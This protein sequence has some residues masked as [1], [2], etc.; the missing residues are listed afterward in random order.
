MSF[1]EIVA[2][3]FWIS[4]RISFGGSQYCPY[5]NAAYLVNI[6]EDKP[7]RTVGPVEAVDQE[8]ADHLIR[9]Q[10]SFRH[11]LSDHMAIGRIILRPRRQAG[12][13]P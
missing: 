4:A 11:V 1:P 2:R 5:E 13:S 10:R 9:Y 8:L 6:V 3:P 12:R 7:D